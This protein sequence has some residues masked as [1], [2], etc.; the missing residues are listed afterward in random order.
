MFEKSL[1][2]LIRGIRANKKNEQ[3]YISACLQEI[4]N[5]VKA[6]DI[7]V[8]ANAI[9]KLTYLQMFGYD[10]SWASFHVVEVMSSPKFLHKRTGY[11][12]A[13]QSFQQDTDV[14][15]L[16]TN[17]T[18]K[19]I[20]SPIAL[21]VSVT[22]NGLSHFLTP[23][24]AQ[25]L[26]QDLVSMLNHSKPYIRKK[27]VLVLYKVF[28]KFPDGLRLSFPRLKDKLEDP[29]PSVV[30]AA[31]NVICELARKNPKNY[32]SLA[33]QL[34]KLLTTSS[35]NWMLIKI[36]KLFGALTPL[37]PRL[38]KKLLPSISSLIQTTPAMSLLYE[39]IYT[40]IIGGFFEHS[41]DAANS[42]AATCANKLRTFL[43]DSDQNL[44]YIGLLAM[45]RLLETHPRL[46][47]EHRDLIMEC[48]DD[49]DLSIRLRALDIVVG[50]VNRK[51]LVDIVKRL[52]AHLVPANDADG[53]P[54]ASFPPPSTVVDPQ[55]RADIIHRIIF[56]CSQNS[57]HNVTN[58]EW[59]ITILVGLTYVPDVS[60]GDLLTS[61]IMDV[62]V[63]VKSAREFSVKQMFRI[64][65]DKHFYEN[66]NLRNSNI[67]VLYAAAWICGEYSRF[68]EDI[69]AT[70][71]CM[72]NP[73]VV[74]LPAST[75]A[76]FVQN[77]IKIYSYWI[78][79]LADEW[80]FEVQT[81][82]V[83][84]TEIIQEKILMFCRSADLEVQERAM[85]V[86]EIFALI[87]ERVPN[88]PA[89][90][91]MHSVL[92]EMPNLFCAYELNPVA[93]KAQKK[94]PIPE[95]LDLDQ[96]INDPLPELTDD[97][98]LEDRSL[99]TPSIEYESSEKATKRRKKG[100]KVEVDSS[101]DED[102]KIRRRNARMEARKGDP[103]YIM[104]DT[105]A[106]SPANR[107]DHDMDDVDSIPI[108]KLTIDDFDPVGKKGHKKTKKSKS[109]SRR[110]ASPPPPPPV[111]AEED[112]PE[113]AAPD[114]ADE[115]EAKKGAK[116]GKKFTAY[117]GNASSN[118]FSSEDVSL[119]SVD[120]SQPVGEDEKLPQLQAYMSPEEV[121]RREQMRFKAE[122]K[123][124]LESKASGK[125]SKSIE[126]PIKSS[127]K[128]TSKS[129][130]TE[131]GKKKK[132]SS[133]KKS[134]AEEE[135]SI[136]PPLDDGISAVSVDVEEPWGPSLE[137]AFNN[138][139]L[140]IMY[141]IK[142]LTQQEG[143]IPCIEI[144]YVITNKSPT[145]TLDNIK[146][147]PTES[148]DF[149]RDDSLDATS[150]GNLTLHA[151]AET[152][153]RFNVKSAPQK[154]LAMTFQLQYDAAESAQ[155]E[156]FDIEITVA[157]FML[158]NAQ[159]D[160][161][162]FAN[163]LASRGH[164]FGYRSSATVILPIPNDKPVEEVL[165]QGLEMI[166]R[167]TR[168]HVVEMVPGAASLYGKSVQGIEVA[169]LLKYSITGEEEDQSAAM[170][171]EIKCTDGDFA[172]A[173]AAKVSNMS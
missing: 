81:E 25:V 17:L 152:S 98:D 96:W 105:K 116:V 68:L 32:L 48:I 164:E 157:T 123:A 117:R 18:K 26:C 35:N 55:Y 62:G 75:Q 4:R 20:A 165:T 170:R 119:N 44:K 156:T 23:D 110:A 3:K 118:V 155:E 114:S 2:D 115:E 134:T 169:G 112:A 145:S 122:K 12:A 128:S 130:K 87:L 60:V 11:L 168:L 7:D 133:K 63:R 52:V 111:Y 70:L 15:M 54:S 69:P 153:Y 57:Y 85:N 120:L 93:P 39:C 163:M 90:N 127:K 9:A 38:V 59:Y 76:V 139:D 8:K 65:S 73:A 74:K 40:V 41:G 51:N 64:L 131:S 162:G 103:F 72:L 161:S 37:E 147:T 135:L 149:E 21:D 16:C 36:I 126:K 154:S 148:V 160:P 140:E 49:A 80:N 121:Q 150:I 61:Q 45:G 82:F 101:D 166:S 30:S 104:S 109:K 78:Q 129:D 91:G 97:S 107:M 19:D 88:E 92:A 172:N 142:L 71:E 42:L 158:E 58:F 28:L 53:D 10:M 29:D 173:L 86:R 108:V 167:T 106:K 136:P 50:M 138:D 99:S 46:V 124:A 144:K 6:N 13:A 66:V 5:E 56:I 100:R 33:P 94:V 171:L 22:I 95:G 141:G 84:V 14:L 132:S 77:I 143:D 1:T 83:K 43:E 102:E 113:N 27:V 34:Y 67:D 31:V 137:A 151:T 79:S 47:A 89:A 125:K 159:L 24:L 146:L